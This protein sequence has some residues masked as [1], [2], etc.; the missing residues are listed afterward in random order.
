[1]QFTNTNNTTHGLQAMVKGSLQGVLY[2]RFFTP[3]LDGLPIAEA[4]GAYRL[5][6]SCRNLFKQGDIQV[7]AN[8]AGY[9]D[10][11]LASLF[12]PSVSE[13]YNQVT[14]APLPVTGSVKINPARLDI[15]AASLTPGE[16]Y[17][18]NPYGLNTGA[19]INADVYGFFRTTRP[20]T[21]E[22]INLVVQR[23]DQ[24]FGFVNSGAQ[25]LDFLGVPSLGAYATFKLTKYYAGPALRVRFGANTRDIGFDSNGN[26]DEQAIATWSSWDGTGNIQIDRWYDQS[27]N[28]RHMVVST[29]LPTIYEGSWQRV[30]SRMAANFNPNRFLR[31]DEF[32]AVPY[33]LLLSGFVSPVTPFAGWHHLLG[34]SPS[35]AV[36]TP[37]FGSLTQRTNTGAHSN[38]FPT[39]I[40]RN[41][42]PRVVAVSNAYA[43]I[44]SPQVV[45]IEHSANAGLLF[46]GDRA[47]NTNGCLRQ[48]FSVALQ[49]VPSFANIIKAENA[50]MK[51]HGII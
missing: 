36:S 13:I 45:T 20:L 5:L 4:Y 33:R 34:S 27:G 8:G 25:V 3:C 51:L 7:G 22:E 39:S 32:T 11:M 19:I 9:A 14:G 23:F 41:G 28:G 37:R 40:R 29:D 46:F 42:E 35:L 38:P 31:T 47:T 43:P 15:S 16:W 17:T 12:P 49:E 26:L 24:S 6:S 18:I 21:P 1:M 10:T 44:T 50:L 2:K 30:G 48:S